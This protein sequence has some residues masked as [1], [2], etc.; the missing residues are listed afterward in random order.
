MAYNSNDQNELDYVFKKDAIGVVK[1]D[2][3]SK[4]RILPL[5]EQSFTT[6]LTFSDN[7]WTESHSLYAGADAAVQTPSVYMTNPQQNI[8]TSGALTKL[9]SRWGVG[10]PPGQNANPGLAGQTWISGLTNWIPSL[11]DQTRGS[12]D[13][14]IYA[15]PHGTAA[16]AVLSTG[17]IV[18]P[19][20][21]NYVFDYATGILTFIA[22]PALVGPNAWN[23]LSTTLDGGN[24]VTAYDLWITQGYR[25]TG[26]TLTDFSA[27]GGSGGG[28]GGTTIN[29]GFNQDDLDMIRNI[30]RRAWI[31]GATGVLTYDQGSNT[32]SHNMT[33]IGNSSHYSVIYHYGDGNPDLVSLGTPDTTF[34]WAGKVGPVS[35]PPIDGIWNNNKKLDNGFPHDVADLGTVTLGTP[36]TE[37]KIVQLPITIKTFVSGGTGSVAPYFGG[38]LFNLGLPLHLLPADS[39]G[40]PIFTEVKPWGDPTQGS[41]LLIDGIKYFTTGTQL[42]IPLRDPSGT[43]Y[44]YK[45]QHMYNVIKPNP[46]AKNSFQYINF[47]TNNQYVISNLYDVTTNEAF[48]VSNSGVNKNDFYTNDDTSVMALHVNDVTISA[49]LTNLKGLT[50]SAVKLYPIPDH[51]S[52][53]TPGGIGSSY[54]G[55]QNYIGFVAS[56]PETAGI[57]VGTTISD[58]CKV[59]YKTFKAVRMKNTDTVSP[60]TPAISNIKNYNIQTP[61]VNDPIYM[62]FEKPGYLCAGDFVT[63]AIVGNLQYDYVL[64]TLQTLPALGGIKHLV[65]KVGT[66]SAFDNFDLV[67]APE[68]SAGG[69]TAD[70]I[71]VQSLH[72]YWDLDAPAVNPN[73]KWYDY[74][75]TFNKP[76]GCGNG[77][78]VNYYTIKYN[79]PDWDA[80]VPVYQQ[81]VNGN[82]YICIGYTGIIKLSD[83]SVGKNQ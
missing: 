27:G 69:P 33:F 66:N 60:A 3:M 7:I 37:D 2:D 39:M 10:A 64:P 30:G 40:P 38:S 12:Y 23:L 18:S 34:E 73:P 75:I 14:V 31:E 42:T 70:V 29:N 15:V 55:T 20:G 25:Y 74:N 57:A 11:F 72:V 41:Y 68:P 83:L 62:P 16:N 4:A 9:S 1:T 21:S 45:V 13:L 52:W 35:N 46:F 59:V 28:G 76:N 51:G 6:A 58:G 5:N 49:S 44:G 67:V 22:A 50:S 78:G 26:G 63:P 32:V 77:G 19:L 54:S 36:P 65:I 79:R 81:G 24:V 53:F 80:Y 48:N 8:A 56:A 17:F 43:N 47:S 61:S 82:M 71:D